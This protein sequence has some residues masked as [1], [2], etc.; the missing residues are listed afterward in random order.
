MVLPGVKGFLYICVLLSLQAEEAEAADCCCCVLPL[1]EAAA[2][3]GRV[4][5]DLFNM[6]SSSGSPVVRSVCC[7]PREG[8]L[9]VG[10]GSGTVAAWQLHVRQMF[11]LVFVFPCNLILWSSPLGNGLPLPLLCTTSLAASRTAAEMDLMVLVVCSFPRLAVVLFAVAAQ[12]GA[13]RAPG[14]CRPGA[15]LA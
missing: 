14:G 5:Q 15:S 2:A 6:T 12:W 9:L 11:G 4:P 13:R 1:E 3:A 7:A 8:C 10:M